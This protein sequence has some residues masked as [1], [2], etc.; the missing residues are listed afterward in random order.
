MSMRSI[1]RILG[2][3]IALA[4]SVIGILILTALAA[5]FNEFAWIA[6]IA[7]AMLAGLV[8]EALFT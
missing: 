1:I 5:Q 7:V 8:M 4:A 3:Y 2:L 6:L